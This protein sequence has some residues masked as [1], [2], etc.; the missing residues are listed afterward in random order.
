MSPS[1]SDDFA[2]FNCQHDTAD[3][4]SWEVNGTSLTYLDINITISVHL[5]PYGAPLHRLKIP[6]DREYNQTAIVC[7]AIFLSGAAP[8]MTEPAF[9]ILQGTMY[10][11]IHIILLSCP[12]VI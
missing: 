10:N 8:Q 9:L 3:I 12:A 6:I 2:V 11:I 4:V 7:L 1:S 5:L